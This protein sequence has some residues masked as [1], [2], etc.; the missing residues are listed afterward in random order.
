VAAHPDQVVVIDEA[1]VDFGGQS[2]AALLGRYDN[3]L[4][5]QTLSK[6]RSLAG[7]RVGFALGHPDLIAGLERVKNS[8]NCY[9]LGQ[10]QQAGAIAAL[11]DVAYT[12]QTSN[13]IIASRAWLTAQMQALGFEVLPSQANFV[14]AR[15]PQHDGAKLAKAARAPS[16]CATSPPPASTSSCA[17]PSA[18]T[19][20]AAS[21]WTRS[22][23]SSLNPHHAGR[24]DAL[25]V[26][27]VRHA[28]PHQVAALVGVGG[29]AVQH[30][31]VIGQ[32]QRIGR[33]LLHEA[34]GFLLGHA[35]HDLQRFHQFR[36]AH[37]GPRLQTFLIES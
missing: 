36:A 33:Q 27:H 23:R 35:V 7:L 37:V 15:H 24:P 25:R 21:W 2:A 9:P 13:A 26:G 10:V 16:W 22:S 6:S 5:I 28:D 34:R 30:A 31:V 12:E 20:N 29:A 17:S 4:V 3:L 8:F 19:K 32:Q 18:P 14:F 11:D 1:Y